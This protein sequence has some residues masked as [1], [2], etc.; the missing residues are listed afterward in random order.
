MVFSQPTYFWEPDRTI[1]NL[2][3]KIYFQCVSRVEWSDC[4]NTQKVY[5]FFLVFHAPLS[6]SKGGDGLRDLDTK[7]APNARMQVHPVDTPSGG[8]ESYRFSVDE[9]PN[10]NVIFP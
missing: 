2:K 10:T 5:F 1:Q 8:S 3:K 7:H 9:D 4:R 6:L